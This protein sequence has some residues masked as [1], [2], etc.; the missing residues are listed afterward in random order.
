VGRKRGNTSE[1]GKSYTLE[2]QMQRIF[3]VEQGF[4][5]ND[6]NAKGKFGIE[7]DWGGPHHMG[8]TARSGGDLNSSRR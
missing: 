4:W 6:R 7:V 1:G 8:L 2:N 5:K 3:N